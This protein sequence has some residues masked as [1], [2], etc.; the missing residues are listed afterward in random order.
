MELRRGDA[1][2]ASYQAHNLLLLDNQPLLRVLLTEDPTHLLNREASVIRRKKYIPLQQLYKITNLPQLPI[3]HDRDS[4]SKDICF[5]L[6]EKEVR[7]R[8]YLFSS[9][10]VKVCTYHVVCC[11]DDTTVLSVATNN[12]PRESAR[13]WVL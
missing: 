9:S 8:S 2:S 4:V 12:I 11:Q 7:I 3:C 5:I 10:S 1:T 6:N 13:E